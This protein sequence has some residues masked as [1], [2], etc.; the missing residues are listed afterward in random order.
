V[1][2]RSGSLPPKGAGER[3]LALGAVQA[4][5]VVGVPV[6]AVAA[7][8]AGAPGALGAVIG[9]GF[10]LLLFG[11]S[12]WMLAR[13]VERGQRSA[14][15]VL[16]GGALGRL[17]LYAAALMGLSRVEGIHRPSLALA[18]AVALVVTLAYEMRLLARMPQLFWVDTEQQGASNP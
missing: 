12:A 11:A 3:R 17:M 5:C 8:V 1:T 2:A 7:M 14:M 9:L 13:A 15:G 16:V 10:V 18:T 4:L 6:V